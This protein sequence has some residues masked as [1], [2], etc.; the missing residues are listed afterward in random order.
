M[1]WTSDS[2][3]AHRAG[4]RRCRPTG[5]P[6]AAAR[7]AVFATT[8]T[9]LAVTGHHMASGHS[10]PW[11]SVWA[12][13]GVLFVLTVPAV[14]GPRSLPAVMAATGAAQAALHLWLSRAA[15]HPA[16]DP[17]GMAG[18]GVRHDAHE[19]WHAGHHGVSMTAAHLA[20][21]LLVAWCLQRADAACRSAG[22]HLGGVLAEVLVRL[23]PAAPSLPV[24]RVPRLLRPAGARA[25]APPRTSLVLAHAVVRRG[26]P[27]RSLS[28]L[29]SGRASTCP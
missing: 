29:T 22:E 18:H 12:A 16:A 20:A 10:A 15:S 26:P 14:R 24:R 27:P 9:A 28:P 25:Q 21:A 13:L 23:I 17:H 5:V 1:S 4:R 19:T 7:A 6:V 11:P 3:T 8:S 2:R